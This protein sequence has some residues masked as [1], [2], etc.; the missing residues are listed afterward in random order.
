[1]TP[2]F[3]NAGDAIDPLDMSRA[4][5]YAEHRWHEPFRKLRAEAPVYRCEHSDFGPY[6]S[7]SS[8]KL[9]Q[10]VEAAHDIFS[11]SWEKGGV[12]IVDREMIR[13]GQIYYR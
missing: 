8:H 13:P 2:I 7:V 9:I 1:M 5:I 4:E 10:E 12:T 3:K 11:S 6:W